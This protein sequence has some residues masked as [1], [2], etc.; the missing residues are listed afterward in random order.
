MKRPALALIAMAL[1]GNA[2]ALTDYKCFHDCRDIGYS[3]GYCMR[4]C[5]Y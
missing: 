3:Y 5:E 4:I 2:L 1:A